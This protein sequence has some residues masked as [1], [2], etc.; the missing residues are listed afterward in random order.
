MAFD[1]PSGQAWDRFSLSPHKEPTGQAFDFE[2]ELS[3][4]YISVG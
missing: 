3:R 2:L 1:K 4:Q